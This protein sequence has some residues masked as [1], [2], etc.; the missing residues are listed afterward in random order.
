MRHTSQHN[1]LG[2]P[3]YPVPK[4]CPVTLADAQTTQVKV[5]IAYSASSICD[6]KEQK[7][8]LRLLGL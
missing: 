3:V 2:I 8:F 6:K 7:H 1:F 4:D 5:Q